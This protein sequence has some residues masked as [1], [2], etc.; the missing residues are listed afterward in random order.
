M[1]RA[2]FADPTVLQDLSDFTEGPHPPPRAHVHHQHSFL[3]V[4]PECDVKPQLRFSLLSA[5][6]AVTL[7]RN[8]K[9]LAG[10]GGKMLLTDIYSDIKFVAEVVVKS[11]LT[12]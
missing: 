7:L 10:H 6:R 3:Y 4:F 1:L 2:F 5:S 8:Q 9:G 12:P 11:I